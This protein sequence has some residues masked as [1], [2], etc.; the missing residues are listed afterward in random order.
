GRVPKTQVGNGCRVKNSGGQERGSG[1]NTNLLKH[2]YPREV[3]RSYMIFRAVQGV[4]SAAKLMAA[5][6]PIT[7]VVAEHPVSAAFTE[8]IETGVS[9]SPE[10]LVKLGVTAAAVGW[11]IMGIVKVKLGIGMVPPTFV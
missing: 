3:D 5:A 6:A 11:A 9:V 10:Q 1:Q 8:V 4:I 7:S 2:F